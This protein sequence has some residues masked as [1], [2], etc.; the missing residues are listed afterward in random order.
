[1]LKR[2]WLIVS[3][4]IAVPAAI[5]AQGE[6]KYLYQALP[7][8]WSE[9]D[10]GFQQVLPNEDSW[11][12]NF[13]DPVLDSI[14]QVAIDRNYSVLMAAD[15]IVMAKANLASARSAYSPTLALS[16][17][18]T[19]QQNSGN[20]SSSRKNVT[21]YSSVSLSSSWQ[22]DLFGTIRNRVKAEKEN[23]AASKAEYNATMVTL[24]AEVATAY[25]NLRETQQELLVA[26]ENLKSQYAVVQ[27]TEKQFEAGLNSKLDVAQAYSV[28]YST[29]ASLPSIES[30]IVQ[31]RNSLAV[32]MG[33]YPEDV[34]KLTETIAPLPDYVETVSVGLPASLLLRRPDLRSDLHTVNSYAALVGASK[35]DWLPEVFVK[36]SVGYMSHDFSKLTNKNSLTYEIA[37]TLTWNF[38]QG[39]KLLQAT[40]LAKAQ[41]DES[42]N[43]Y[44][45]DVLTAVQ[46]VSTAMSSYKNSIKEIL[47]MKQMVNQGK[48]TFELSLDLYKQGLTAFQNVLDAQRS[49]LQ[50]ENELTQS[51]GGSLLYLIQL[52]QALGGGWNE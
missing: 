2:I 17:G 40:R 37:P 14:I 48:Q 12:K 41:L 6:Y 50:Y 5:L 33:M 34:R 44:N 31:Y 20:I 11:W 26:Q 51:K 15:R 21:D 19:K 35:S 25:I 39:T 28:Y 18:W 27:I 49:L 10:D 1:M 16:G 8:S 7:D 22:V 13:N 32:L 3:L 52:Y 4:W 42:I 45:D 24:C 46:E 47:A 9:A 23:F 38:F 30:S 36:G 43:Q 29:K